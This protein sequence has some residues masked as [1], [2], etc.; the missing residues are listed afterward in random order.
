MAKRVRFLAALVL[1]AS[2]APA[3][4]QSY[5][6]QAPIARTTSAPS[7]HEDAVQREIVERFHLGLAALDARRFPAAAA[8]FSRILAL[9]PAEPQGS[10]AAYDLGIAQAN[11][12]ALR[13]ASRSFS[14][15]LARDPGFLAAM[16]NAI[17][18]DLQRG[19][20][21]D[22]RAVA[23]RFVAVAPDSARALY[24]RGLVALRTNDLPTA[25]ADFSR[26]LRNDPQYAVAHYD[27][28]LI[29]E[30]QSRFGAAL[31]EFTLA[32]TLAPSYARARF[33][34]GTILLRRGDRD[35]A[36]TAFERAARDASDDPPLRDLAVEMRDAIAHE[37]SRK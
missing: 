13:D 34:V 6:T 24:S 36:R 33:A 2:A 27:M 21:A 1:A 28:G 19:D 7:L 5:G 23:D 37:S 17:A 14:L 12:G 3:L 9:H 25:R 29:D 4:A 31:A 8:E 10:T 35:G 11:E 32:L 18:V 15:A 22:A 20:L 16:A 30:R 26:L